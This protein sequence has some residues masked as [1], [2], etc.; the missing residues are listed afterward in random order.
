MEEL[1]RRLWLL[2]RRGPKMGKKTPKFGGLNIEKS[3]GGR[4]EKL[5]GNGENLRGGRVKREGLRVKIGKNSG[6][7]GQE[8]RGL[9][10]KIARIQGFEAKNPQTSPKKP[11]FLPKTPF[12]SQ[13]NPHLTPPTPLNPSNPTKFPFKPLKPL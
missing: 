12:K 10:Q 1:S 9:K 5:G 13:K 2:T 3:K 6:L 11:Q 7:E 8:F 4:L